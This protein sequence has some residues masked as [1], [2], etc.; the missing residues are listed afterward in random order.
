MPTERA[1]LLVVDL[2]VASASVGERVIDVL[3]LE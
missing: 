1:Q 2:S 3:E